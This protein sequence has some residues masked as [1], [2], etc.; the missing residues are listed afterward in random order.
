VEGTC[1]SHQ[2]E[3]TGSPAGL[4]RAT[5]MGWLVS[6]QGNGDLAL[7]GLNQLHLNP[8]DCWFGRF[9]I[10]ERMLMG[11]RWK[12]M[13]HKSTLLAASGRLPSAP[14][15]FQLR[16]SRPVAWSRAS[17]FALCYRGGLCSFVRRI[18]EIPGYAD[19]VSIW[20]GLSI[21]FSGDSFLLVVARSLH[22]DG[23]P[24][25]LSL[26]GLEADACGNQVYHH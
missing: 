9:L 6:P 4:H 21:Q 2:I 8:L 12:R 18:L 20:H 1:Q 17:I 24:H 5:S 7:C 13:R 16:S 11:P 23:V 26:Y 14:W 19:G 10:W 22:S 25:G 15:L 3:L